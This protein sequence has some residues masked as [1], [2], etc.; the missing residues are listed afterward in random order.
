[1][2]INFGKDG[3][4]QNLIKIEDLNIKKIKL[5][6]YQEIVTEKITEKYEDAEGNVTG[7]RHAINKIS[8][9]ILYPEGF[10]EKKKVD[11][12]G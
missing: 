9:I 10:E 8:K 1:M 11:K 3:D 4:W 7:Y 5:I 12:N 2:K 6:P